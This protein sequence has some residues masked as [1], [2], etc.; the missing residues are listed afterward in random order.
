MIELA[1]RAKRIDHWVHLNMEFRADLGW[2]KAFLPAWNRLCMMQS[3][4]LATAPD[5]TVF[6]D[7]SGGVGL[8]CYLGW[9]LASMGMGGD[10]DGATDCH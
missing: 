2:W 5:I 1:S 9:A 3:I 7:A 10:M 4:D 8:W 6:S